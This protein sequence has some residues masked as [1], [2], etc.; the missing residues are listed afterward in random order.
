MRDSSH[1]YKAGTA[2]S[3]TSSNSGSHSPA[4]SN[5]TLHADKAIHGIG[6]FECQCRLTGFCAGPAPVSYSVSNCVEV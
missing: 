5:E 3:S 6:R 2:R 1:W 4:L